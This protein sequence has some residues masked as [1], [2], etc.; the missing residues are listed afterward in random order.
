MKKLILMSLVLLC[1]TVYAQKI[2]ENEVDD[3]TKK[4]I[5]RTSW[6]KLF[7]EMK[8]TIYFRI[9]KI[10]SNCYFEIKL[11]NGS[12]F[13]VDEGPKIMFKLSNDSIY[14]L[15]N[16]KY[17][18]TNIGE[19]SIGLNGSGAQGIFLSCVSLTDN[20]F[21]DLLD[22]K[23]TKIRIYTNSGYLEYDIKPKFAITI[24]NAINL[25]NL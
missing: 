15:N 20:K 2:V 24:S 21:N 12:V 25:I 8:G 1:S 4:S 11:M 7:Y 17:T 16:L 3:F 23:V 13:S 6:E 10:D 5:K 19:G 18:I 9:S 14:T 22:E